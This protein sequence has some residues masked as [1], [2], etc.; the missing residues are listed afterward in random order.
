[1]IGRK[2]KRLGI[3]TNMQIEAMVVT[4]SDVRMPRLSSQ[5][6]ALTASFTQL[7][8]QMH[9]ENLRHML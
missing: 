4:P 6:H 5:Q 2:R 7:I 1:M 9:Q 3:V 8:Q